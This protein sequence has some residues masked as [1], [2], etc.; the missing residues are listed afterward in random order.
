MAVV[1][2]ET[3]SGRAIDTWVLPDLP[4]SIIARDPL[5]VRVCEEVARYNSTALAAEARAG[6][7]TRHRRS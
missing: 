5:R 4:D 7:Y 6:S 3:P 2:E 1:R